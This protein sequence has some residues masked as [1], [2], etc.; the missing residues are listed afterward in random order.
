MAGPPD[1]SSSLALGMAWVSRLIAVSL[2]MVVPGIAGHWLDT[3]WGTQF[4]AI[5]G[6]V[7]G[8]VLG[9]WHLLVMV[10]AVGKRRPPQSKPGERRK[11]PEASDSQDLPKP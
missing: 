9:V 7:F 4:L 1:E 6:F 5:I 10:G 8:A 2:E 11:S 3:R